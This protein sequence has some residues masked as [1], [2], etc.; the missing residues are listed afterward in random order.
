M[1]T[2]SDFV[3]HPSIPIIDPESAAELVR[4][5]MLLDLLDP[6]LA[7]LLPEGEEDISS[8]RYVLDLGCGQGD[9]ALDLAYE[10]EELEVAGVDPSPELIAL[11]NRKARDQMLTNA[12]FGVV[13]LTCAPF[14]FSPESVDFINAAFLCSRLE[15][16][17][18]PT[19]LY[20]CRQIL[21]PGGM[22]RLVE[23]E[24]G[25]CS[26]QAIEKLST[27]YVEALGR[28][29][30]TPIPAN[31][32]HDLDGKGTLRA[33][34]KEA[35]LEVVATSRDTLD[36]SICEDAYPLMRT[37]ITV[38]FELVQPFV[39][40]MQ[41]AS[42]AEYARLVEQAAQEIR[43]HTFEGRWHLLTMWASKQKGV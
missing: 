9:W 23:C 11:A 24:S 41:V 2:A 31:R 25:L 5:R 37:I 13:D 42:E 6:L 39:L 40:S 29:G 43:Q 27:L 32:A 10:R 38:F 26:S 17:Q 21:K 18:W 4:R 19:L 22:I 15:E 16:R 12:S 28:A 14:D 35:G 34:L 20:E 30:I 8:L 3:Y 36:F 33:M 7:R 1:F